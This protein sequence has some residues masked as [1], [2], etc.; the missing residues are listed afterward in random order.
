MFKVYMVVNQ[1]NGKIYIGKT[2][3]EIEKRWK[4]HVWEA[5]NGQDRYFTRAIKRHGPESFNIR[6]I[7][8]S[9]NEEEINILERLYIGIYRSHC[10]EI[11][12]NST[13][14]GEGNKHNKETI[15]KM[16]DCAP[17]KGK[18]LPMESR[19]K[20]SNSLKGRKFSDEHKRR[21]GA[22]HKGK[23][24]SEET[25]EKLRRASLAFHAGNK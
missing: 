13:M 11:G 20:S 25:R 17:W 18:K 9:E 6:Q 2:S 4:R 19:I 5:N 16:K 7:D 15:Q 22:A 24:V 14:G 3:G 1:N 8:C 12:Y 21:I 10:R 23:I